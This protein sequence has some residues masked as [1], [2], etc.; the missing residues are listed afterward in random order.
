MRTRP[1]RRGRS[2]ATS[3]STRCALVRDPVAA[4][5]GDQAG[6]QLLEAA[7]VGVL[8]VGDHRAVEHHDRAVL[9]RPRPPAAGS[10]SSR[11]PRVSA[12]RVGPG[13]LDGGTQP[14]APLVV[15]G[16]DQRRQPGHRVVVGD[17]ERVQVDAAAPGHLGQPV[18][19]RRS[20]PWTRH[21]SS[22]PD[23]SRSVSRRR[24]ARRR[25]SGPGSR[26]R[27]ALAPTSSRASGSVA[28][29]RERR[30]Q[31][32]QPADLVGLGGPGQDRVADA[33][34]VAEQGRRAARRTARARVRRATGP[35][36]RPGWAAA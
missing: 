1:A 13:D 27:P 10:S 14:L 36:R 3:G 18:R 15:L 24:C 6:H 4:A 12:R 34:V 11:L 26:H 25:S 7:P 19:A 31:G 29:Q 23:P 33:P 20:H 21:S 2:A 9:R 32:R 30:G 16:P 8:E 5:V 35:R 17:V 22:G 28:E